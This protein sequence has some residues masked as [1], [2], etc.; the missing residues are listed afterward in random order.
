MEVNG[1][2][3]NMGRS[4]SCDQQQFQNH[5]RHHRRDPFQLRTI[6]TSEYMR[7]LQRVGLG[8]KRHH[9]SGHLVFKHVNHHQILWGLQII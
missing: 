3:L 6:S 7:A 4:G 1:C 8:L 9:Q 2:E 5:S